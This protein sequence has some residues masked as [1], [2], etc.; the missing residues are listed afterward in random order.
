VLSMVAPRRRRVSVEV[1]LARH[2][3]SG[4]AGAEH[5]S[6][7]ERSRASAIADPDERERYRGGRRLL[8]HALAERTGLSPGNLPIASGPNGQV[9]LL[10]DG[11]FFSLAHGDRW[12]A[13][14]LCDS[15]AVGAAAAPLAEQAALHAVVSPLLPARAR[16]EIGAVPAPRQAE[17]TLRWWLT[18]EAAVRACGAGRD[19]AAQCLARVTADV[20]CPVPEIMVAVAACTDRA[21]DVRWRVLDSAAPSSVSVQAG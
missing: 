2:D 12:Y 6:H 3:W 7:E 9:F 17:T 4:T 10:N 16:A 20:S 1:L 11:P 15:L 21:L 14:A 8:R 5:L 19:Q 13:L 18:T